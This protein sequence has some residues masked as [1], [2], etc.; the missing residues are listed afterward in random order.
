MGKNV[1]TYEKPKPGNK[2]IILQLKNENT[3]QY[4][5]IKASANYEIATYRVYKENYSNELQV[6]YFTYNNMKYGVDKINIF[7][8]WKG[9]LLYNKTELKRFI[10]DNN[11][12]ENKD[13]WLVDSRIVYNIFDIFRPLSNKQL[14]IKSTDVI[15]YFGNG[16]LLNMGYKRQTPDKSIYYLDDELFYQRIDK[17][18]ILIKTY[19]KQYI[20][21]LA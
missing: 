4:Y 17:T 20:K 8:E 19:I 3:T 16:K 11:L 14:N 5:F 1:N 9:V 2:Y 6:C 18:T 21:L 13:Y 15:E 12:V 7:G 10:Q